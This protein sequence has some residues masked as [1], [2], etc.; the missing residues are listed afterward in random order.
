MMIPITLLAVLIA[1]RVPQT[2]I[3]L[4][5]AFDVALAGLLVPFA[6]GVYWSKANKPAAL[7]AIITG[8]VTRLVPTIYGVENTLLY[9]P[10]TSS[11]P[12]STV[13]PRS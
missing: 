11:A 7:A 12:L 5:L 6:L 13:Y 1:V 2:G 3:L 8:S 4:T 9:I 10:N